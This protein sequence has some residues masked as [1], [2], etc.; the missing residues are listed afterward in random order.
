MVG[1]GWPWLAM[2]GRTGSAQVFARSI[3]SPLP[4]HQFLQP[5][6]YALLT[7][8]RRDGDGHG[9]DHGHAQK[10]GDRHA[11]REIVIMMAMVIVMI[12]QSSRIGQVMCIIFIFATIVTPAALH[13]SVLRVLSCNCGQQCSATGCRL[14]V[15]DSPSRVN[16]MGQQCSA[17]SCRVVG[18]QSRDIR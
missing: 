8:R 9:H 11:Q 17:T 1:H 7:H 2:A 16:P 14:V 18:T 13:A 4:N 10:E 5:F 15:T 3:R 12:C 6:Y